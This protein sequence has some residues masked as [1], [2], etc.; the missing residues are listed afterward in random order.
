MLKRKLTFLATIG[1]TFNLFFSLGTS[2]FFTTSPTQ[3]AYAAPQGYDL[4]C[5]PP[6][7]LERGVGY[8]PNG[9]LSLEI[10]NRAQIKITIN[11]T[12]KCTNQ[13]RTMDSLL[14]ENPGKTKAMLEEIVMD[15][16]ISDDTWGY[17]S[18]VDGF[19]GDAVRD[20]TY[21]DY[22][23]DGQLSSAVKDSFGGQ[24]A[25]VANI[26]SIFAGISD[27]TQLVFGFEPTAFANLIGSNEAKAI[28]AVTGLNCGDGGNVALFDNDGYIWDCTSRTADRKGLITGGTFKNVSNFNIIYNASSDGTNL[29]H[30]SKNL[31]ATRSF[32]WCASENFTQPGGQKGRF[33]TN[34]TD[35]NKGLYL[36]GADANPKSISEKSSSSGIEVTVKEE[37]NNNN[38]GYKVLVAGSASDSTKQSNGG[39]AGSG[40]G[41]VD[42][43]VEPTCETNGGLSW[44]ICPI[45]NGLTG[46]SQGI[47]ENII[48]PFLKTKPLSTEDTTYKIWS[49]FRTL[50]NIVLLFAILFVVFGQAIGGG[51]V[52]AYTAR[53]AMPRILIVAILINISYF[54]SAIL[55]DITNVLGAGVGTLITTPLKLTDAY[56]Y[57]LG[58][59]DAGNFALITLVSALVIWLLTKVTSPAALTTGQTPSIVGTALPPPTAG[60]EVAGLP[61]PGT[62]AATTAA[63]AN[64]GGFMQFFLLFIL[65]PI[66]LI[67][68]SIFATLII[69]NG[70]IIFLIIIAPVA[71]ALYCLPQ[72]EKWAKKWFDTF[73]KT[74]MVYP[75]IV[76]IFAIAY[77]LSLTIIHTGGGFDDGGFTQLLAKIIGIVVLFVPLALIPFSFKLAGGATASL[78]GAINGFGKK[79]SEMLKGDARD[80][81]SLRNKVR[82]N[83][84][85]SAINTGLTGAAIGARAN[86]FNGGLGR[87]GRAKR[88]NRAG[89]ITNAQQQM[90]AK[91]AGDNPMFSMYSQSD[92][93]MGVLA[94]FGSAASAK[95]Y[96]DGQL[97]SGSITRTRHGQMMQA[98]EAASVIG[99]NNSNR[100]AAI[101]NP[102]TI[103]YHFAKGEKGW[104]DALVG[105][106]SIAG[107]PLDVRAYSEA[108]I[109]ADK[110]RAG[111]VKVID[112]ANTRAAALNPTFR[113][114]MDEFQ[115]IAKGAGR[116]DLS[117]NTS[118][119]FEYDDHRAWSSVGMY[120]HANGKPK[121]IAAASDYY[122]DLAGRATSGGAF[123]ESETKRYNEEAKKRGL[124]TYN[125]TT[126][127]ADPV[128]DSVMRQIASEEVGAFTLEMGQI[129]QS[130]SGAGRDEAFAQKAR[131]EQRLASVG[132]NLNP[133]IKNRDS[134]TSDEIQAYNLA[135]G[136]RGRAR[137]MDT[138]DQGNG[139]GAGPKS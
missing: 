133:T 21:L 99:W 93:E 71:L 51:L 121:A 135:Q 132:I 63:G 88:K 38:A 27:K 28:A 78:Y 103:G 112:G 41:G 52:D 59:G 54:L 101:L 129:G 66:V 134:P 34:C 90:L 50:G 39:G 23:N 137:V 80:P 33:R 68:L 119:N 61:I 126:R 76:A 30:V 72:T 120:Q 19:G 82:N 75:I 45:I 115:Y 128:S 42:G 69:R 43:D 57:S 32:K 91:K 97:A 117:G 46:V 131:M 136:I 95:Q 96:Y 4:I 118:G 81:A 122:Y 111:K 13:N 8:R 36:E 105:M 83:A 3:V 108:E 26:S 124:V 15:I 31:Q 64:A 47:F 53:K 48:E 14:G 10:L 11:P 7:T 125:V 85:N 6:A 16:D 89:M 17:R 44:V 56:K 130:G 70:L 12:E 77:V 25:F 24:D 110:S 65:L 100:R 9:W 94:E 55:I 109:K 58:G 127:E 106:A 114:Q 139:P 123:T 35:T 74:L 104:N 37:G 79:G 49:S 116:A 107:V 92:A 102:A 2:I 86:V 138:R 18:F 60:T 87:N 98:I 73:V 20:Q 62:T 84:R 1:F 5:V 67:T 113:A 40:L 22:F 29:T